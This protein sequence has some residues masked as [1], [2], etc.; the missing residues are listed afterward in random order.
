M[1]SGLRLDAAAAVAVCRCFTELL[2]LDAKP[3]LLK[4]LSG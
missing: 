4:Q 1:V 3:A 2:A